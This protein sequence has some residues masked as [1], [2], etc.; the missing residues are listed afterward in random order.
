MQYLKWQKL[1]LNLFQILTIYIF[2]EKGLIAKISYIF[3]R[4]SKANNKYLKSFD[5]KQQSKHI[6]YLDKNNLYG[7]AIPNFFQ[8]LNVET[9][10]FKWTDPKQFNLNKYNNNSSK[11]YVFKC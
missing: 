10:E 9:N 1:N 3:N 8:C 7:Y 4:Y 2:F 5:P 11:D 6:M